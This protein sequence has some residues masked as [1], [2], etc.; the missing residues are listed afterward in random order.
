MAKIALAGAAAVNI[1]I[2]AAMAQQTTTG[3]V[4]KVDRIHG[5]VAIQQKQDGTVGANNGGATEE[6][7]VQDG[8]L[9]NSVHAGDKVSASI[10]EN[11]G[12]KTITKLD[13]Q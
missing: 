6:F 1:L 8:S 2:S 11:A 4:T 7:K 12:A 5:T 10:T 13:R 9:L 3:T